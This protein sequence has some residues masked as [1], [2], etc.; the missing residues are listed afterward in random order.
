MTGDGVND[1]PALKQ[2]D[3]AIAMGS[4]SQA[5]RAVGSIVLLDSAFASVPTI[6]G[7]GR[8]VIANIERVANLFITKT[9]YA[10][11]VATVV[12]S[13]AWP[14]PFYPR[15]FTVLSS[16]TIGVPAFF[17]ALAPGAP[18]A[19]PRF[20]ARVLGF[21]VPAG[22]GAGAATLGAY[23]ASRE[24]VHAAASQARMAAGVALCLAAMFVLG[25]L[26]RPLSRWRALL[27]ASMALAAV[28]AVGAPWLRQL[29]AFVLPSEES[30]LIAA[31]VN[32][33]VLAGL[34][35]VLKGRGPGGSSPS[36]R[37]A[38]PL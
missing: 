9:V 27:V 24:I 3:I 32:I 38:G 18:R 10:A 12:G 31:A 36:E 29:L 17:L 11:L 25:W 2:A 26:A 14:Y 19:R 34:A 22:T 7:E 35:L 15:Q 8:R 20:L 4:G 23:A 33:P 13:L 37:S 30:L 1:I 28:V 21:S 6:L 5:C 16:L